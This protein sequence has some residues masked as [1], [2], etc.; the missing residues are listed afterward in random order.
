MEELDR[1]SH[2]K[3]SE[4]EQVEHVSHSGD[5]VLC[6]PCLIQLIAFYTPFSVKAENS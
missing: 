2:D 6:I 5:E 1:V 3:D 4:K